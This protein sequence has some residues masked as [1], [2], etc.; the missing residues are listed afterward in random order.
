DGVLW[1]YLGKGDGTFDSRV[2]IGAGWGEYAQMVGI[3]DSDSD[4]KADLFVTTDKGDSYVYRGTGSWR[5]PF[6][7]RELTGLYNTWSSDTIS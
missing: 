3:G 1:L 4:G 2:R 6:A 5:A 7:P